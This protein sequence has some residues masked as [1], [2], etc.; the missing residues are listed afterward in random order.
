MCPVPQLSFSSVLP[1]LTLRE[2]RKFNH[3]PPEKHGSAAGNSGF[4][5]DGWL[6]VVKFSFYSQL[7]NAGFA[8]AVFDKA[9]GIT[10]KS[11]ISSTARATADIAVIFTAFSINTLSSFLSPF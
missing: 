7:R 8:F 11:A 6:F 10:A 9:A 4:I 1:T 5:R 3:Q 2:L